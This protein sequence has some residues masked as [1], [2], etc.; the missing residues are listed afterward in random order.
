MCPPSHPSAMH[1]SFPPY[2]CPLPTPCPSIH[3][4][5]SQS[6]SAS[7][8]VSRRIP[9]EPPLIS[10]MKHQSTFLFNL[11]FTKAASYGILIHFVQRPL[12]TGDAFLCQ[13]I[14]QDYPG[15][16]SLCRTLWQPLES[17]VQTCPEACST[18]S[19]LKSSF[20]AG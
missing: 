5:R 4:P 7:A 20:A 6:I 10:G 13:W 17:C 12:A 18:E 11:I 14:G 16:S 2:V 1:N 19:S 3:G 15:P 9:G 8:S